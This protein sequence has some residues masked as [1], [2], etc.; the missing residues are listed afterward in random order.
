MG[1]FNSIGNASEQAFDSGEEYVKYSRRYYTLLIFKYLSKSSSILAKSLLIGIFVI[2]GLI[3]L[4][5]SAALWLAQVVASVPLAF[6]IVGV[7]LFVIAF[8]ISLFFKMIDTAIIQKISKIFFKTE[9][10]L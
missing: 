10:D 2:I 8:I 6:L 7:V 3:F 1:V 5:I 4:L 9:T